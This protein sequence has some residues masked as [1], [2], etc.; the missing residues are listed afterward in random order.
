VSPEPAS[1]RERALRA[2]ALAADGHDAAAVAE[3]DAAVALEPASPRLHVARAAVLAE[4]G[5]RGEALRAADE[6]ARLAPDDPL[7]H[8]VRA[9]ALAAVGRAADAGAA[10]RRAAELAPDD[11][12]VLRRLAELAMD[13]DPAEAERLYRRGLRL[14]PHSAAARAGLARAL[15]RLGRREESEAEFAR[16]G[17]RD[18]ALLEL[19][20][21]AGVLFSVLLQAA[22][23]TFLGVLALGWIP[24]VVHG[25]WP[26]AGLRVAAPIAALAALA[27][28][29]LVAWATARIRRLAREAP[30]PPDV[31]EELRDVAAAIA[32]DGG[33]GQAGAAGSPG[34]P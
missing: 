18:P 7:A 22:L 5:R 23:A 26:G 34:A 13:A 8:R 19:R 33:P 30:L 3:A 12:A 1:A 9:A 16:A 17:A 31:R 20:R 24:D 10:A 25:L 15:R 28:V 32:A 2:L 14:A 4:A 27:P 11:P 29:V 6:A 21:R